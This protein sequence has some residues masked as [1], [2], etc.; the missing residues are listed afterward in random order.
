[1][2]I[3]T[4]GIVLHT[5]RYS[6]TS[7]ITRIYTEKLGLV[8]YIVKGVRSARS[9]QKAALL[10]PLTLLDMVVSNR[11]NRQLQFI[12]EFSRAYN[13]QSIPFDTLKSAVALLLLEVISK[14]IREHEQN[15]EMFEFIYESFCELDRCEK[16][17]PD[18]HLLFL[19][20]FTR[21]LGF[22][23][24]SNFSDE[25]PFFEMTEG[26]F[27]ENNGDPLSLD[28]AESGLLFEL[29]NA[30]IFSRASLKTTRAQRRQ[31]LKSILKYYQLHLE[32]FSLKSPE[33]LEEL[34]E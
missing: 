29:M 13:Y 30:S 10:Q 28:K 20:H 15:A 8:S 4:Q 16:L 32:N 31:I 27:T 11:E 1:M 2:Y 12:K 34:L 23:P 21:Y 5:T 14:S 6:E 17:L 3:K 19:V 22:M 33:I 25:A 9:K 26:I 24:H 18:F 7:V